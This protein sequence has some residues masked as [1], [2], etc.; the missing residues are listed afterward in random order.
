VAQADAVVVLGNSVRWSR[1]LRR[2]TSEALFLR[3]LVAQVAI[4]AVFLIGAVAGGYG[5][6]GTLVLL[7]VFLIGKAVARVS[8]TNPNN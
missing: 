4:G 5:L 2:C 8:P 6:V 7:F 1:L 3:F